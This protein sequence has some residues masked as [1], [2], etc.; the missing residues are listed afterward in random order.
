MSQISPNPGEMSPELIEALKNANSVAEMQEIQRAW[1]VQHGAERDR[2]SPDKLILDNFKSPDAAAGTFTRTIKIHG[3]DKV[4]VSDS[5]IGLERAVGKAFQE[6][7]AAGGHSDASA[8]TRS[9]M[10]A[11]DPK[12]GQ[13]ID[14][15]NPAV[16]ADLKARLV[17]GEIT[18][19][20]FVAAQPQLLD[21]TMRERY[22]I[23]PQKVEGARFTNAWAVA[24]QEFLNSAAGQ[25][26][27]GGTSNMERLG[28][29]LK[30]HDLLDK[31]TAQTLARA[32][33]YMKQNNL[34]V[35]NP[36]LEIGEATS[37]EDLRQSA[38][39]SVGGRPS[40][41]WSR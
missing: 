40:S 29:I 13:F 18:A 28:E 9:T 33:R 27:P 2:F 12:T 6:A 4:I 5:E 30:E 3:V 22:G 36:E 32:Y 24:T 7:E 25:D 35:A 21:N 15:T 31:P 17:R 34:L 20:E 8:E 1:L 11:R 38:W 23:D 16:Q 10:Q 19:E 41:F 14:P 39:K 26:W 37:F